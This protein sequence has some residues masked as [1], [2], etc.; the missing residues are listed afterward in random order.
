MPTTANFDGPLRRYKG[1]IAAGTLEP[2]SAQQGVAA[3]LD[4]LSRTITIAVR[5][6]KK[7]SLGWFMARRQKPDPIRGTYIW[8]DVGRGKTM[9][10]DL[11]FDKVPIPSKRR[12]HFHAFMADVHARIHAHRQGLKDGTA[13]GA[14]PIPPVAA[15][16]ADGLRLLCFDE[17]QVTDI[18][19]AMV[20]GRLFE[21]LFDAGVTVVATS[22]V[23]PSNLYRDGLNRELFLPFIAMLNA[24][25]DIIRLEARTDFRLEKLEGMPVYHTPGGPDADTALDAAWTRLTGG[26]EPVAQG[27]RVTGR[28]V[29]APRTAQGV[30]RFT[31][32]ELCEAPLAAKDFLAIAE[33]FHTIILENIPLMGPEKR[34]EARRFVWL[35]D[36]LYDTGVKLIASAE[37]PAEA[38]YPAGDTAFEF[39]RTVSRLMEMRSHDYLARG[40]GITAEAAE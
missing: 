35:I 27:L 31:F 22:N 23:A 5:G 24:N 8:G 15:D 6:Q 38:L 19:D 25:M 4:K 32:G 20:L 11:F 12:V 34:N 13:K 7:S 39:Q 36:A 9:L 2:D 14:D 1:L 3:R 29:T 16:L 10:M 30:A 33:R 37:G 40:H 21:R 28:T 17:F 26:L 18:A